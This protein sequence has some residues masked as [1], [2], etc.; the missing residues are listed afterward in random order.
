MP[1]IS[2]VKAANTLSE[3]VSKLKYYGNT[4]ANLNYV[5]Q[6]IKGDSFSGTL[7]ANL[8]VSVQKSQD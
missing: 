8:P 6:E 5:H 3:G 2:S 4:G 1:Y 7:G